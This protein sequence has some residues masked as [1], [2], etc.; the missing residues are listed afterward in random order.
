MFWPQFYLRTLS[1][2][3]YEEK[4]YALADK[5]QGR[6]MNMDLEDVFD[7][8]P[9][10]APINHAHLCLQG[11]RKV[12]QDFQVHFSSYQKQ[13]DRPNDFGDFIFYFG[14]QAENTARKQ[15]FPNL[16]L[17]AHVGPHSRQALHRVWRSHFAI[18]SQ[19]DGVQI[20]QRLRED[21]PSTMA[22]LE[23]Y[24]LISFDVSSE[25][26][27][28]VRKTFILAAQ[29]KL[30]SWHSEF[31]LLEKYLWRLSDVIWGKV[32]LMDQSG[33]EWGQIEV[34]TESLTFR[35]KFSLGVEGLFPL[36]EEKIKPWR[37]GEDSFDGS[38]LTDF[39]IKVQGVKPFIRGHRIPFSYRPLQ[40]MD[41]IVFVGGEKPEVKV[42]SNVLTFLPVAFAKVFM[43]LEADIYR[44]FME[45]GQ[46]RD[47][48]KG[49]LAVTLT[50]VASDNLSSCAL[51]SVDGNSK[52]SNNLFIKLGFQ[53]LAYR[54][55]PDLE[56]K[57]EWRRWWSQLLNLVIHDIHTFSTLCEGKA[58]AEN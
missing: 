9:E 55:V 35:A 42:E 57:N 16:H 51:L 26:K 38:L 23:R 37:I 10:K 48:G 33:K 28:A 3:Y 45:L 46:S 36:A 8:L 22:M 24:L 49:Q 39:A 14:L 54:L 12:S 52:I 27:S 5:A 19:M 53:M 40:N 50:E 18:L 29:C 1:P 34:D 11:D 32:N 15:Y 20:L 4:V 6:L 47:G 2:Q 25:V 41:Q 58:H 13:H 56:T 17:A 30:K 7:L 31:P 44:F 21:F 43:G